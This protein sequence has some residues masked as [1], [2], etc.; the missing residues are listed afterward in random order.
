MIPRK[1]HELCCFRW[2]YCGCPTVHSYL[3]CI[4]CVLVVGDVGDLG[5]QVIHG[6]YPGAAEETGHADQTAVH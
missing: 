3:M 2:D 1:I 5:P 4:R 6:P